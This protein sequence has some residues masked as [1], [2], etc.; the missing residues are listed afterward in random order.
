MLNIITFIYILLALF[1]LLLPFLTWL[2][3]KTLRREVQELR[4]LLQKQQA[5]IKPAQSSSI[6][7]RLDRYISQQTASRQIFHPLPDENPRHKDFL[8]Q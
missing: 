4:C 1:W 6:D 7:N 8:V 2:Q 5:I 3:V